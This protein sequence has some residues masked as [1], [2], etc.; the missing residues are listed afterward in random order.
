ML[1]LSSAVWRRL[2]R[3]P[4][5]RRFQLSDAEWHYLQ[6]KG[7]PQVLNHARDFIDT[8]LAPARISNDGRQ[9]PMRGHPVFV[10]QHATATCCRGCLEK[11]HH[12]P[13]GRA[14]SGG[15][16]LY[17]LALLAHWLA[18]QTPR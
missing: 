17:I 1:P 12:I 10:A 6:T 5:R 18:A 11:W 14:L 4:F 15:E 16:K 3:S 9:T 2:Q 8:R 7:W 13:R